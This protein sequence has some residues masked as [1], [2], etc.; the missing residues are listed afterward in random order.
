MAM[1]PQ[2]SPHSPLCGT[3]RAPLAPNRTRELPYLY[4]RQ[5]S[6]NRSLTHQRVICA[7]GKEHKS[8][9]HLSMASPLT[10]PCSE[11]DRCQIK[12][13]PALAEDEGTGVS[14]LHK[15]TPDGYLDCSLTSMERLARL[16]MTC[17][18]RLYGSIRWYKLPEGSTVAGFH[19][20]IRRPLRAWQCTA[21]WIFDARVN[22]AAA[23][24][25][26]LQI[27]ALAATL[28][29]QRAVAHCILARSVTGGRNAHPR[30]TP[31]KAEF[32]N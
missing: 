7:P 19:L 2:S 24:P 14:P 23:I 3:Q 27:F 11:V 32:F 10:R 21:L 29:H 31:P 13:H 20:S 17:A 22:A 16:R 28:M 6:A 12:H 8:N 1:P 4:L 15:N 30:S 18:C 26:S 5:L 25:H 9:D